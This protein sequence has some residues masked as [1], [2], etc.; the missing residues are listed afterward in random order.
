MSWRRR[1]GLRF[2]DR[3]RSYLEQRGLSL[4]A[5]NFRGRRG[6]IDLV[7]RDGDSICFVEVKYRD[8]MRYGGAAEAIPAA[9]RRRII[10]TALQ[11]LSSHP[12]L[13]SLA[14]RFD[15]LLIQGH[16]GGRE[17]IDWIR[18]AFYAE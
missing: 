2:E 14:P 13:A 3:A 6:E 9:K 5:H 10:D 12:D 8:S 4:L 7:M 1:K 18:N 17:D 15:A 16:P 11:Y